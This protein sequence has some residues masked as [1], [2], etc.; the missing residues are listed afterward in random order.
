MQSKE[1]KA[2]QKH[3]YYVANKADCIRR[4][5]EWKENNKDRNKKT[6]AQWGAKRRGVPK[7]SGQILNEMRLGL[8]VA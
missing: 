3:E 5:K 4:S 2:A 7:T 8:R 1:A 6:V